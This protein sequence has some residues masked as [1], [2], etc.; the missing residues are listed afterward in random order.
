MLRRL[1]LVRTDVS[2]ELSAYFIRVTRNTKG[3]SSQRVSVVT[4]SVVP[5]S[6]IFVTLMKEALSSSETLVLTSASRRNIQEDDILH[7][8]RRENLKSYRDTFTFPLFLQ[9]A[10]FVFR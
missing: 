3:S 8:H 5:S 1:L 10:N 4:G 9:H 7:S 6:P 2:E